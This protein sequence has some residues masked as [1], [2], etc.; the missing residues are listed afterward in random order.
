M[1]LDWWMI[2]VLIVI[3]ALWAEYR[4]V[5]GVR[6][7]R[8]KGITDGAT[9]MLHILVEDK[10]IMIDGDGKIRPRTSYREQINA[11][12]RTATKSRTAE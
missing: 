1:F 10:V 12:K 2:G 8:H 7:G 5:V 9:A 3:T 11:A 4:N 6:Q